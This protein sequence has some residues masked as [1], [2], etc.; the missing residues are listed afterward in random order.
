MAH[1]LPPR[2]RH[3]RVVKILPFA[4]RQVKIKPLRDWRHAV[5]SIDNHAV[6][7]MIG[8]KLE[9]SFDFLGV[10]CGVSIRSRLYSPRLPPHSMVSKRQPPAVG[11][12]DDAD[13]DHAHNSLAARIQAGELGKG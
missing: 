3:A 1:E 13:V 11:C 10:V 8:K 7:Q 5:C 6:P 4:C 9:K 12:A 2:A